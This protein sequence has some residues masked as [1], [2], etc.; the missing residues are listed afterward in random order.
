M[1]SETLSS[2]PSRSSV[3]K[4]GMATGWKWDRP[5]INGQQGVLLAIFGLLLLVIILTCSLGPSPL[6]AVELVVALAIAALAILRPPFALLL[7]GLGSSMPAVRPPLLGSALHLVEPPLILCIVAIFV[8][9]PSM[10]LRAPHLLALLFVAISL[11]SFAHEP[12]ISGSGVFTPVYGADKRLQIILI[13]F[14]ALF[15]G[16]FLV[17]YVKDVPGFLCAMLLSL[18]PLYLVS[19]AQVLNLHVPQMLED[20]QAQD[21]RLSLGRLWGTFTWPST[22]GMYLVNPFAIALTCWLLAPRRLHRYL[23]AGMAIVTL[24]VIIGTGTRSALAGV[25][26]IT[27]LALLITRHYKLLISMIPL[28]AVGTAVF[29]NKLTALLAHDESSISDRLVHWTLSLKL[30]A[31]SPWMGV[32]LS[33][34][35]LYYAQIVLGQTQQQNQDTVVPHQQYLEW[36]VESGVLAMIVHILFL[37]S[38]IYICWQAYK[39]AER[40]QQVIL[41]A[42]ILAVLAN[43][44]IGFVDIPLD[45][46]ESPI[47][48]FL[49]LGLAL[50]YAEQI[51]YGATQMS[52]MGPSLV[53]VLVA[54]RLTSAY[55]TFQRTYKPIKALDFLPARARPPIASSEATPD[56]KK[57]SR[58]IVVQVI[59]WAI[60]LPLI[61]PTTALL[62]RYFGPVQYGEYSVTASFLSIF[63]LLTGTGMDPRL[64]RQLS[65]Q[66]RAQ[67]SEILSYAAGSRLLSTALGTGLMALLALMLPVSSD[68]RNLLLL[69]SVTLGFSFSVNCLRAIYAHGFRAE[70]RANT[71]IGLETINRIVT[72]GLVGLVVALRLPLLW[73][74]ALIMYS[75]LP[76]FLIQFWIARQRF[77]IRIRFSLASLREHLIGS[78]PLTG[79]DALTLLG[80]QADVLLLMA[81]SNPLSVGIYALAMRITDPLLSIAFAYTNGLYPL[82]CAK[83]VEG[84]EQFS[85]ISGEAVRVLALVSLAMAAMISALA[86]SIV[87]L[88]GG[89]QFAS[90]TSAVQLLACALAATFLSQLAART[91]MAASIERRIPYV[92]GAAAGINILMNLALI[93]RWQFVGAGIAALTSE[94]ISLVLF[95]LLLR[96]YLR[97]LPIVWILLRVL[98][99]T[100]PVVVLMSWQHWTSPWLA[101]PFA[102]LLIVAGYFITRVMTWNDIKMIQQFL[103]GRHGKH[104]SQQETAKQVAVRALL[105]D[106]ADRPTLEM[107]AVHVGGKHAYSD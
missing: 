42:A 12:E 29:F 101:A 51:R 58:I 55:N 82:L 100:T 96:R 35:R 25:A 85:K 26:V 72:A 6:L 106:I 39:I 22:F 7:V 53:R 68:Q 78:L 66:P 104:I 79:F 48:L 54:N 89:A 40:K 81:L 8:G 37:L 67:W 45:Q 87:V 30:I 97:L 93:P 84:R 3:S 17:K 9:R 2:S 14:A 5:T 24:L 49:L 91:C 83:F 69:G 105:T 76:F 57:T 10:R 70:Q 20:I 28:V 61:F 32:G 88:L 1:S 15:C 21:P 64:I 11:I 52:A 18:L 98:L 73:A 99:S 77:G 23:G 33:H 4:K 65:Q 94:S 90:A 80:G 62:T 41:L 38:I 92:T 63:A 16:T 103:S 60:A 71:L 107:P 74:Y 19:L 47:F 59:S 34:F 43:M 102:F 27:V 13:M 50:G 86:G 44:V 95:L 46:V 56:A 31:T 36:A 75:D